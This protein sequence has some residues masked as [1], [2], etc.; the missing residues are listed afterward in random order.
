MEYDDLPNK[1][2]ILECQ[3]KEIYDKKYSLEILNYPNQW[4]KT[5]MN[6]TSKNRHLKKGDII[7]V[8]NL[9]LVQKTKTYRLK[10]DNL[11]ILVVIQDC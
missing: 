5:Y 6:K 9:G 8:K 1:G 7:K 3:I 4:F 11:Y 2:V 10:F